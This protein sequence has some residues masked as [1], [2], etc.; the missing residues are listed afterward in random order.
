MSTI[1][2][3]LRSADFDEWEAAVRPRLIVV[4]SLVTTLPERDV[5]ELVEDAIAHAQ[6][7][8]PIVAATGHPHAWAYGTVRKLA[9]ERFP[10]ACP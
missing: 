7:W 10:G 4:F 8:W 1:E 5:E 3:A 6:E 9:E 2:A